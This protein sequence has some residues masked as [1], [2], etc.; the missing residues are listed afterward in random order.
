MER[1][2][3]SHLLKKDPQDEQITSGQSGT[4]WRKVYHPLGF[5]KGY[6]FALC[7]RNTPD[8]FISRLPPVRLTD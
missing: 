7:M 5:K 4:F 8:P 3:R 6:N 1:T 2:E